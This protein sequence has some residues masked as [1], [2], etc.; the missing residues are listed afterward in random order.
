MNKDFVTRIK[1]LEATVERLTDQLEAECTGRR[2]QFYFIQRALQRQLSL[3][4]RL[5]TGAS[6]ELWHVGGTYTRGTR[7]RIPPKPPVLKA[8][9]EAGKSKRTRPESLLLQEIRAEEEKNGVRHELPPRIAEPYA[10][11]KYV[12]GP[13]DV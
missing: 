11:A 6:G 7:L 8:M 10:A 3:I 4:T 2:R 12:R 5:E 1:D 9:Q 13:A